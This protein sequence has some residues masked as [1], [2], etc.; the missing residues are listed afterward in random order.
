MLSH[1][2]AGVRMGRGRVLVVGGAGYIGS[3]SAVEL[4]EAGYEVV[5]LDNLSTGYREALAGP[6]VHADVRDRGAVR[7]VLREGRFD[8]VMH[9]AARIAV[10]ESV[11]DPVGYYDN[12]VG[13]TLSLLDA[14]VESGVRC[15]VF[16]SSAA[17]YGD[18]SR[19]PIDEDQPMAPVS[20]YGWTKAMVEQMLADL[21][22]AG[23]LRATALRYFNASGAALDGRRGEA[24]LPETHLIPLA[25]DAAMGHRPPL[26]IFGDDYPT[27]DGTCVRDYIHVADL[28]RAHV[29]ALEQLL[30]G[31]PGGAFN[32]GTGAGYTVR[33]VLEAVGAELGTPV[34]HAVGP[35]RAGD[36]PE[37]VASADRA[38][39]HL[40]WEP[41]CSSLA[42]IVSSAAR[43]SRAPRYGPRARHTPAQ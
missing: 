2:N 26:E 36:P 17:V 20:P 29:S 38:R 18:P 35:R 41:H 8:A 21:R 14:M 40:G 28:A 6:L 12:N 16:S 39:A 9:F 34:P 32:V 19:V 25:L 7:E 11:R 13:G 30:A 37:L 3:M 15:L 33:E 43:W 10:G 27:R 22:A 24:H 1:S 23:Q 42:E 4:V 31:D 5:I